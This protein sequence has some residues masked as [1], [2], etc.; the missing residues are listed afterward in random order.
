[1]T[2]EPH[3]GAPEPIPTQKGGEAANPLPPKFEH[4]SWMQSRASGDMRESD[5]SEYGVEYTERES[6]REGPLATTKTEATIQL[7]R[8]VL[9]G[10]GSLMGLTI[11]FSTVAVLIRPSLAEFMADFA[12]LVVGGLIGLGGTAVGFLFGR[13]SE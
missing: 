5:P 11:L 9:L 12:Q 3:P 13:D 2:F 1:M 8:W 10:V 7:R 4:P 6:P